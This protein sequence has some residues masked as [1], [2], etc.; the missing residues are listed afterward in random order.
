MKHV[1]VYI[2]FRYENELHQTQWSSVRKGAVF[3]VLMGWLSLITYIIYPVAFIFGSTIMEYEDHSGLTITDILVVS[4][5]YYK[6]TKNEMHT[7]IVFM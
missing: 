5:S 4:D 3:G 2:T 6:I 7:H 1:I